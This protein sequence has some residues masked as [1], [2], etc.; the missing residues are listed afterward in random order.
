MITLLLD[1]TPQT[2]WEFPRVPIIQDLQLKNYGVIGKL[3][4]VMC[5][6]INDTRY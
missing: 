3:R 6:N 5:F 2:I 4:R 1:Y